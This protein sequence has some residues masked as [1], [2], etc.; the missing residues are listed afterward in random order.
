MGLPKWHQSSATSGYSLKE[1][2]TDLKPGMAD[3]WSGKNTYGMAAFNKAGH[4]WHDKRNIPPAL[5]HRGENTCGSMHGGELPAKR[6]PAHMDLGAAP[7]RVSLRA[8]TVSMRE[9]RPLGAL[10]SEGGTIFG[11]CAASCDHSEAV[12]SH[13][14]CRIARK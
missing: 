14:D 2:R 3:A 12:Q 8:N 6:L 11:R 9:R 1:P 7:L 13:P 5:E 10:L 4:H